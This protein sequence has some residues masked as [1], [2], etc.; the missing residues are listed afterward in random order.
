MSKTLEA[1]RKLPHVAHVDDER[2]IGNSIIVTLKNEFCFAA[3]PDYGVR[4]FDT[5]R[6]AREGCARS[7]V[8]A[9]AGKNKTAT[10]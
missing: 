3:E 9:V 8:V 2:G 10:A 4:G 5:V 6:E 1:I 7:A